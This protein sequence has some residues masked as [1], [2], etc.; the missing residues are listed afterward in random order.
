MGLVRNSK[1]GTFFQFD[2]GKW[3][4]FAYPLS[5]LCL[6]II[7]L[8]LSSLTWRFLCNTN[9]FFLFCFLLIF[10]TNFSQALNECTIIIFGSYFFFLLCCFC[11]KLANLTWLQHLFI[12]IWNWCETHNVQFFLSAE[13]YHTFNSIFLVIC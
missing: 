3:S 9:G 11:T 2:Y 12:H 6:N 7:S 8:P 10:I 5:F 4:L 1:N 13:N